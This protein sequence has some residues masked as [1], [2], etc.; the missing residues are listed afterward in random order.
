VP[1]SRYTPSGIYSAQWLPTDALGRLDRASLAAHLAFE[2]RAGIGGVLALGSTGEFPHFALDERKAALEILAELAAPL[3]V[4]ANVSDI[5]PRAAIE[6]GHHARALGVAAIALMPPMFFPMSPADMLAYFLHVSDAVELPVML[7]NFPELA[8]KRI[9]LETAA[10]F[11][12]RAP[13]AAI[14]Q[15]GSQF[16]YHRDLVALGREKDFVVMSGADTRLPE[17]FALGAAGCIGGLV[18]I[19][20]EVMVQ[21]DR[22][23]RQGEPADTDDAQATMEE[24]GRIIDRL[25][26]PL[27]VAAGLEAR[28]FDPGAPKSVVSPDSRAHYERIVTDLTALFDRRGLPRATR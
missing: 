15:S 12:D 25:T 21:L 8:G 10:A 3:P 24:I 20:P 19:V 1:S 18:N 27:N 9:E 13:M 23:C 17:A 11:A 26:F 5:R 28:G 2:R 7:Y 22:V 4:I 6:L 16:D 14:K